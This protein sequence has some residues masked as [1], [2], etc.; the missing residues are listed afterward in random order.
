MSTFGK[1]VNM[2]GEEAN[3]DLMMWLV[4]FGWLS[5]QGYFKEL[6]NQNVVCKCMNNKN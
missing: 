5:N 6:T 2:A 3:D 1:E 4:I